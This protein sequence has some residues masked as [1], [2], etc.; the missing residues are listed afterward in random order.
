MGRG[1]DILGVDEVLKKFQI[2]RV[3]QVIDFLGLQG[4]SVDNIPGV[5]GVGP[6]TAQKLLKEYGDIEGIIENKNKIKGS[7]GLKI[8]ENTQSALMSKEL[9]I[10]KIDVPLSIK[11]SDLKTKKLI[12]KV[13][14]LF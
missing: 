6:K 13:L 4:D 7:V 10:I 14:I 3:D 1:A 11:L 2:E 12:V 5:P 8:Q 9:A